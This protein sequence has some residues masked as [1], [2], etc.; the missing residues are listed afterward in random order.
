MKPQDT[1]DFAATKHTG[2]PEKKDEAEK[3]AKKL[4]YYEDLVRKITGLDSALGKVDLPHGDDTILGGYVSKQA[5]FVGKAGCEEG[6]NMLRNASQ[7]ASR[8]QDRVSE[9]PQ[10]IDSTRVKAADVV[11]SSSPS[12]SHPPLPGKNATRWRR[13]LIQWVATPPLRPCPAPSPQRSNF[14]LRA[15]PTSA[16]WPRRASG[17]TPCWRGEGNTVPG[18]R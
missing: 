5:D 1:R 14:A 9:Q 6:A 8:G 15:G 12:C 13:F 10:P 18:N 16:R 17:R 7:P 4:R 3:E 2:L 11:E